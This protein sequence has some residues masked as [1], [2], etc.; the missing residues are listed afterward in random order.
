MSNPDG[1]SSTPTSEKNGSAA[2]TRDT[3]AG[4]VA[5]SSTAA[6]SLF[7]CRCSTGWRTMKPSPPASNRT[8]PCTT[9]C[10]RSNTR[11][12]AS[13]R[14]VDPRRSLP[15][16]LSLPTRGWTCVMCQSLISEV[17]TTEGSPSMIRLVMF[18]NCSWLIDGNNETVCAIPDA[19][20]DFRVSAAARRLESP[21]AISLTSSS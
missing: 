16:V 9:P 12:I 15:M 11:L 3:I 13:T 21:S 17:T 8:G 5:S 19:A 20:T 1:R 7:G 14:A 6:K 4:T 10:S 18:E 2:K